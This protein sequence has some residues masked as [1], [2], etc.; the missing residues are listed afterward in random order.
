MPTD[1]AERGLVL[2][3]G[4]VGNNVRSSS[5]NTFSICRGV[6]QGCVLDPTLSA[7]FFSLL[8]SCAFMSSEDCVFL[9][10]RIDGRLL[11]L[12]RFKPK[13]PR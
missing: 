3:R 2:S 4:H 11:N 7:V 8:F 10:T 1:A 6:K 13:R 9:Y 5:S 12:A